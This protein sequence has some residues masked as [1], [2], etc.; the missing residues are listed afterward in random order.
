MYKK[1]KSIGRLLNDS[2]SLQINQNQN[3]EGFLANRKALVEIYIEHLF[4]ISHIIEAFARE[5][6]YILNR[7]QVA[8]ET[9]KLLRFTQKLVEVRIIYIEEDQ[10]QSV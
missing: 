10:M 2:T 9:V 6:D 5:K 4:Q 1:Y 7:H 3:V 8:N